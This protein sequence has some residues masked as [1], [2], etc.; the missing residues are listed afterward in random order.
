MLPCLF[1]CDIT[2]LK[3]AFPQI[4]PSIAFWS[5]LHFLGFGTCKKMHLGYHPGS[6]SI[7]VPTVGVRVRRGWWDTS[8]QCLTSLSLPSCG[9]DQRQSRWKHFPGVCGSVTSPNGLF[10]A[11]LQF[12]PSVSV[13]VNH[14]SPDGSL[15]YHYYLATNT[16]WETGPWL[17]L[18][19]T[20][21]GP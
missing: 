3:D 13:T 1:F 11:N 15:C 10:G 5:E 7:S 18:L 17:H 16:S 4:C 9:L 2:L 20:D 8:G 14:K 21:T 19:L 12:L 6:F